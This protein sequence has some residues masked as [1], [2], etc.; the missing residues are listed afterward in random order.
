MGGDPGRTVW[1]R[2]PSTAYVESDQRVVVLD[3]D[4]LDLA[5]YVFEGTASQIWAC[6]DGDRT[7]SEMVADLAE[8][9]EVTAD[10]VAPDVR[11]FLDR[12]VDLGLI[13]ADDR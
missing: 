4:H 6:I 7:E 5:P 8:A 11:E 2:A 12:L 9:F 13:V 3:L 1:R 10:V